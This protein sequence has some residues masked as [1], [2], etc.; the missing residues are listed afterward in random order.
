MS[1]R[2][3]AK[4]GIFYVAMVSTAAGFSVR[5]LPSMAVEGWPL[6]FWYVVATALFLVPLG[7]TAAELASAWPKDGGVYDW[8]AEAFGERTG[9]MSVWSI[10]VLNLPWYPTVLAFVAVSLAFGFDPALQDNRLFVAGVMIA[11]FWLLTLVSLR[12]PV[13]AAQFTSFGTLFGSIVPALALI[14]AGVAW[15]AAGKHVALPPLTLARLMPAWDAGKIPFVSSLLLAFTGLEVSGYY[16]L[17]VRDPQRDYPKAMLLAL[18]AISGLSIFATLAIALTVPAEKISLSGG[19]VQTFA[20]ISNEFGVGWA[21]PV[22][23]VLTALGALALMCAWLVGP[24]LSLAAVA[25]HGMLPPIFRSLSV[26]QVPAA[27]MLWQCAV[28]TVIATGFA[29][30]PQV[31]QAYWILTAAVTA[32]LAF[33]YLP[34]F[35]AVIRLRYTQPNAA[36]PFRIPGG[37][38]VVWFVAGTGFAATAF[39]VLVALAPP[40]TVKAIPSTVY[41]GGMIVLA[42]VWMIPWAV[43]LAVRRAS[44]LA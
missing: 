29:L 33:Y 43:F 1:V 15:I 4:L 24:L 21:A 27:I 37:I 8:V 6:I 2:P 26:R 32:L 41:A 12:G 10:V 23:A 20:V 7:L 39:A 9:F 35:A 40:D 25:R 18:L 42:L 5:N 28:V 38:A 30:V 14:V 36:R 16:A 44:W 3:A 34:I 19:V 17:A 13:T 22:L 11:I 31:N